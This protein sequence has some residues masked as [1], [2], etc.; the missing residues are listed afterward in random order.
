MQIYATTSQKKN[1]DYLEITK[2]NRVSQS[3]IEALGGFED[4]V[5]PLMESLKRNEL[6]PF[7]YFNNKHVR[8]EKQPFNNNSKTKIMSASPLRATVKIEQH[9]SSSADEVPSDYEDF[10]RNGPKTL[11]S[12]Y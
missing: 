6:R 1:P 3:V 12:E 2:I 7:E 8:N 4:T 10:D 11:L 5:K 9:D